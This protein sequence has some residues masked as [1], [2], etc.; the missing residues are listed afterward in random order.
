MP[1]QIFGAESVV[2][3]L[4]R[5]FNDVSPAY[6][7]YQNQVAA[8]GT[9]TD[10]QMAFAKQ[11]GAGYAGQTADALSTL[12]LGNLGVLPN[13]ALQT[14]LKDYITAAGV[15]NIGIIAL[16]LG[17]IL[18]GLENATGD[19]AGFKAAA[20]AWNNEVT[21]SYTYS[22][23]PNNTAPSNGGPVTTPGATFSLTAGAAVSE[24]FGPN[25]GDVKFKSTT[26][27]DTFI[28]PDGALTDGDVIDGG[29]GVDTLKV[30]QSTAA[31]MKPTLTSIEKIL[32]TGSTNTIELNVNAN[33]DIQQIMVSGDITSTKSVTVSDIKLGT[34]VGLEKFTA[35]DVAAAAD[36]AT[37]VFKFKGAT[38]SSD[39]ATISLNGVTKVE[40][41]D[42]V[43]LTVADIE[44]LTLSTVTADSNVELSAA[45]AKTVTITG[46][47]GL[48]LALGAATTA[49]TAIDA[50][51]LK[52]KLTLGT[53]AT[54]MTLTLG[55]TNDVVTLGAGK[56]TL[57]YNTSNVSKLAA[58]D[59]VTGFATT[60][61]KIDLKAFGLTSLK[62]DGVATVTAN[63][64]GEFADFF[65]SGGNSY[66]V[67]YSNVAGA[68]A[69]YVD[70][71]KDGNFNTA[72]DLVIKV[73]GIAAP[74]VAG[75]FIFS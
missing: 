15:A 55:Q 54:E 29:A 74:V 60:V 47:K 66:A 2:T 71:N 51:A 45:Q 27:D 64:A 68:E 57:V 16:Q 19:Q 30:T 22:S 53:I 48:T 44:N 61:D 14:A 56:Q 42:K 46:D 25:Q 32:V 38:G 1:K 52:G 23:N 18:S 28:A 41:A 35:V 50:S 69:I 10:S 43:V 70:V 63:P 21:S 6:A 59:A 3:T 12:I 72:T 49:V 5:A 39:A 33:A 4:N 7:T 31:T 75:D 73:A 9:T 67:A 65:K 13:A 26:G 34:A 17:D 11:Y 36:T 62:I 24:V 40:A 58:A 20:V 37:A 8:A